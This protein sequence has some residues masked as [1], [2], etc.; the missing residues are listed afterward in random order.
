M[1]E[2]TLIVKGRE[3]TIPKSNLVLFARYLCGGGYI[4]SIGE[5]INFLN[6]KGIQ[7]K[8]SI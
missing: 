3:F 6:E 1:K 2:V 7:I 5:A 4:A 8:E